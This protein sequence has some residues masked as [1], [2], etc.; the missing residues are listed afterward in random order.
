[1]ELFIYLMFC[2]TLNDTD[3]YGKLAD[4]LII[5]HFEYRPTTDGRA[6]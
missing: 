3:K 1:M 5:I 2:I 6:F 4:V